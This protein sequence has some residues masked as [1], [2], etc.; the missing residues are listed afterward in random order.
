MMR[1]LPPK[2]QPLVATMLLACAVLLGGPVAGARAAPG[3]ATVNGMPCN[4]L[5][6]AYLAWSDRMMAKFLPP[7]PQARAQAAAPSQAP[8]QE[9]AK[10]AAHE[11][12]SDRA[13]HR[14]TAPR[15]PGFNAFAQLPQAGVAPSRSSDVASAEGAAETP[16]D[17]TAQRSPPAEAGPSA[18]TAAATEFPET[19][20]VVPPPPASPATASTREIGPDQQTR[21]PLSLV[22]SLSAFVAFL[23]W[24]WFRDKTAAANAAMN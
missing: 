9:P 11:R 20:A 10:T 13:A 7:R 24:G 12:K 5:C 15:K 17:Q 22:L 2:A 6:R 18:T 23:A 1:H 19:S 3:P 14:A 8:H 21:F 16:V 4:D